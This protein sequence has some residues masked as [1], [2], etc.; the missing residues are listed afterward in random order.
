MS[1]SRRR[2]SV[3]PSCGVVSSG[4][5]GAGRGGA[6]A[7]RAGSSPSEQAKHT[8]NAM[9]AADRRLTPRIISGGQAILPALRYFTVA[10]E[11]L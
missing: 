11:T 6:D 2:I 5:V 7:L 1:L 8:R 3:P 4:A 10:V 9:S